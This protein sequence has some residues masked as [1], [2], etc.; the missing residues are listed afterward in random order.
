MEEQEAV[1]TDI[2]D[3]A[4]AEI[5]EAVESEP[6]VDS[7]PLS[8]IEPTQTGSE[9]TDSPAS[10]EAPEELSDEE[11]GSLSSKANKR[12]RYLASKVRQLEEAQG[13]GLSGAASLP[14]A[15]N[16]LPW[17]QP[18][19]GPREVTEEQYRQELTREAEMV[20]QARM[21]QYERKQ[22]LRE[23]VR[24]LEQVYDELNPESETY[25]EELSNTLGDQFKKVLK[26]DP[27]A[28][29]QEYVDRIM[30]LRES[31]KVAGKSEVTAKVLQQAANQAVPPK[32][33]AGVTEGSTEDE[34]I[35]LQ[36]E[37]KIS[38]E[39]FERRVEEL[40]GGGE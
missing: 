6:A 22:K 30:A 3:D 8:E 15:E 40:T 28:S 18:V 35:R 5:E 32:G 14:P 36:K 19:P 4:S 29:L 20:V 25:N 10:E 1:E 9:E 17:Q 13:Q 24:N 34:L 33:E 26:G 11:Q 31:G 12:I 16:V 37:G 38:Y 2:L 39:E 7:S 27:S 23:E 21:A